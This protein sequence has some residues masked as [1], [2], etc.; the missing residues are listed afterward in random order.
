MLEARNEA[1]RTYFRQFW[2]CWR[3]HTYRHQYRWLE[4]QFSRRRL[5][6][7]ASVQAVTLCPAIFRELSCCVLATSS[8][9]ASRSWFLAD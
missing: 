1:G 4:S 3:D 2:P 9:Q 6:P 7:G 5:M 8:F